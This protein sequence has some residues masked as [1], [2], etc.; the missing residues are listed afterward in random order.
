MTLDSITG[1]I[2]T[3]KIERGTYNSRDKTTSVFDLEFPF[4]LDK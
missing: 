2:H 3:F 1:G 4:T